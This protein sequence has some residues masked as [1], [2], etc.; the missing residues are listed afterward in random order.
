M[1]QN[2]QK[3]KRQLKNQIA[4]QNI[5][6]ATLI[7]KRKAEVAA[8]LKLES[9]KVD[10]ELKL[11]SARRKLELSNKC[12]EIETKQM[13]VEENRHLNDCEAERALSY[14]RAGQ[15]PPPSS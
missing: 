7:E 4:F 6:T 11:E 14:V 3:Q 10:A 2:A 13:I 9:A 1:D 12:I 15:P 5:I 8:E